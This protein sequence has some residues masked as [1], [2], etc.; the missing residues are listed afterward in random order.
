MHP[1]TSDRF[2]IEKLSSQFTEAVCLIIGA[3]HFGKRAASILGE[4]S[5]PPILIVDKSEDRLAQLKDLPVEK[6][7]CDGV[8]FLVENFQLL[9]PHSI[10]VPAIPLHLAA[11]WLKYYLEKSGRRVQLREIPDEIIPTLPHA[12]KGLGE[13]LL[14]SYADFFC[15][16]DCPE[17]PDYCLMTG[18]KRDLP[19][20]ELL[21]RIDIP[22]YTNHVIRSR[23]LAPGLGGFMV[24]DLRNL[25][26]RATQRE[27][28][29]LVGTA[30]RCHGALTALEIFAARSEGR[31]DRKKLSINKRRA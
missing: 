21:S 24:E 18:E 14:V 11:E 16:D 1:D 10:V 30:C 29:W 19:L 5:G 12:W 2:D 28:K 8:R 6:T 15:P 4:T 17:P 7:V 20:Y 9:N 23:Q 13:T 25:L 26:L 27:G 31:A 3:G 22:G